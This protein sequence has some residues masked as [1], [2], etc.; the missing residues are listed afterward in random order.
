MTPSF[1]SPA[2]LDPAQHGLWVTE[3]TL[4]TGSAYHL[5]LALHFRG[6]L[7]PAA[8]AVAWA[9]HVRATPVLAART[10][11][12][13]P[14]LVP[15][16]AP[17]LRQVT[18][19]PDDLGKLRD[20]ETAAR[21]GPD[22]ALIRATL[23]TT[24]PD[25]HLL[26][27]VAHHLVFDGESKDLLVTGLA[28]AYRAVTGEGRPPSSAGASAPPPPVSETAV[29]DAARFWADRWRDSPAPALPGLTAHH[30]DPVTPAPGSACGFRRDGEWHARLVTTAATLGVTR[31]ELLTAAWHTL[32]LRYGNTAP[33]TAIE[34]S[35]RVPGAP[36]QTGL[37]VNELPLFTHPRPDLTFADFAHEVRAELRA[38]YAHRTVPLSRA[39][40][41]LTPRTA[42]C[43]V[44]LSYRRRDTSRPAD[45][46]PGLDVR[47]EWTGFA[48]TARNIAHL[49]LVD[50]PDSLEG[51]L[52]YRTAAFESEAPAC[53]LDHFLTLL[54][55]ALAAPDTA[56]GLL[57]VLPPRERATL[58]AD[59]TRLI[60][61]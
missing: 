13:G 11:P 19:A 16:E 12:A 29:K 10:D 45:F 22:E 46:G 23:F 6:P 48:R 21:F 53:V 56:L 49:Q 25:H 5:G 44:S 28:Q 50:G 58:V 60:H 35:T 24:A 17:P 27:V 4:D 2:P 34:L 55:G 40:R 42:L 8:L 26:L 30:A 32:L 3:R 39:V 31:F 52:Q 33:A 43:P 1:A 18:A 41:G 15:G 51:S 54:D 14:G 59:T 20:E 61:I 9:D 37:H 36:R 38:L 47:T 7:D 57:P